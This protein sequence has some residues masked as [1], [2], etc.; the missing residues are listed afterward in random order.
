MLVTPTVEKE[1]L[2]SPLVS[3]HES[4]VIH[5]RQRNTEQGPCAITGT[6]GPSTSV[7]DSSTA[8]IAFT[9]EFIWHHLPSSP[10]TQYCGLVHN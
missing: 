5:V 9:R 6:T 3:D 8:N 1:L 4:P 2:R 7:V 10:L